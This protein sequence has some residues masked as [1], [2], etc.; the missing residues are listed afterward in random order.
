MF[1]VWVV[2]GDEEVNFVGLFIIILYIFFFL[3]V[4]DFT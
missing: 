2:N 4:I 1:Y 3:W